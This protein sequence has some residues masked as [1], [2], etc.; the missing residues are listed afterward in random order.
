MPDK[1]QQHRLPP[2]DYEDDEPTP[3]SSSLYVPWWGFA[4][5]ILVV[6]GLTCGLWGIVLLSRGNAADGP[7]PTPIFVVI[8]STPTLGP[9][10]EEPVPP[11]EAASPTP[12]EIVTTE[13]TQD[14]GLTTAISIGSI[15]SI[16]GTGK[17]GLSVRQGPGLDYQ[18]V[19]VA[20]EGDQFEVQDGPREANGYTWWYITDPQ[21]PDRFGWAV[22]N[23]MQVV[24]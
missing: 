4:L 20:N 1:T 9:S 11:I 7:T 5:V 12:E 24:P 3:E 15:I 21:N 13:P 22:A 19:F 16:Q 8:T 10:S 17:D 23:F 2:L 6:A 18:Y 14:A